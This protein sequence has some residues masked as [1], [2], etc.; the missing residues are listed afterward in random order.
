MNLKDIFHF[1]ENKI[2]DRT[3]KEENILVDN[4]PNIS[5]YTGNRKHKHFTKLGRR[6]K[7]VYAHAGYPMTW[8]EVGF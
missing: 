5:R 6:F 4:I 2:I 3:G 1:G 8:E 7:V